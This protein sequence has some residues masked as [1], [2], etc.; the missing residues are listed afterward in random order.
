[1]SRIDSLEQM[2]QA[3]NPLIE[4]GYAKRVDPAPG[5]R[6]ERYAQLLC[7]DLHAIETGPAPAA[8][9]NL[10]ERVTALEQEV[11]RLKE[12]VEQIKR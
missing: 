1:M 10:A 12:I 4:R 3:L 9:S 5:S 6:A 2:M 11:A 7:P 8:T